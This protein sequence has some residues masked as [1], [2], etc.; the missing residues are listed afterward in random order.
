[1][2]DQALDTPR[3]EPA[4]LRALKSIALMRESVVGMIGFTLVLF[5]VLVAIFADFLAPYLPNAQDAT[6]HAAGPG[7]V[8][9]N[10]RTALWGAGGRARA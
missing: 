4:I 1:M 7:G 10:G 8:A 2:T 5:W 3:R 9:S 6:M